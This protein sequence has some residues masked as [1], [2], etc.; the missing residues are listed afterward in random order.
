M[1]GIDHFAGAC[2]GG[3][4]EQKRNQTGGGAGSERHGRGWTESVDT[5]SSHWSIGM[6]GVLSG[7]TKLCVG[8]AVGAAL[9]NARHLTILQSQ[10]TGYA[11]NE[12][13]IPQNRYKI[14][15]YRLRF[16]RR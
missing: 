3:I 12:L 1:K 5:V 7:R 9:N 10:W 11:L 16:L 4:M 15:I 2:V 6:E 8:V 13:T 14:S